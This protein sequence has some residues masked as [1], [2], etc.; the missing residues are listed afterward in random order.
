[1]SVK[2]IRPCESHDELSRL[3]IFLAGPIQGAPDWQALAIKKLT[4]LL[5]KDG[6]DYLIASP[7]SINSEGNFS[8][9]DQVLWETLNL[10]SADVI[11][12]YLCNEENHYCDRAYAQTTRFEL[13]EHFSDACKFS[14]KKL[15]IG[16]DSRFT[17]TSYIKERVKIAKT[18]NPR[19]NIRLCH[20]LEETVQAAVELVQNR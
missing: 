9:E 4:G 3:K 13:G 8:F 6:D 16:F 11:L 10:Q 19:S 15:A 14:S 17:G 20:G 2:V 7:R 18:K 1:M 12:F 5:E